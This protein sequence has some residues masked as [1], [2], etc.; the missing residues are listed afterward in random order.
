MKR[1]T[2]VSLLLFSLLAHGPS[3]AQSAKESVKLSNL[4]L[5]DWTSS[6]VDW[7]PV[8]TTSIKT[9]QQKDLIMNVSLETGLWTQ[10][11][12]K[13]KGGT[14]DTSHAAAGVHVRVLVDNQVVEP[15]EVVFARRSQDLTA[16]FG[17]ILQSCSDANADG[18]IT[19]D[20]CLFTNEE[21]DMILDSMNANA[22]IFA[23]P[24]MTAG[25][26]S[27]VVQ[28]RIDMGISAQAGTAVAKAMIG[29]G[30]VTVEEVRL[31]K[32]ANIF[33]F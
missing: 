16:L 28:A 12:V 15:G 29:K 22:F 11:I 17:G 25:T 26:H 6:P 18:T 8:L 31:I 10:T 9:A 5:L 7:R 23:L 24:N 1:I 32:G 2:V 30:S 4:V 33:E 13:S 27:V 20:E 21:L 3:W 14:S 19:S